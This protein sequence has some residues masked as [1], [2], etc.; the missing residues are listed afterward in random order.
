MGR[1]RSRCVAL[2]E[3]C[4]R[5]VRRSLKVLDLPGKLCLGADGGH[6]GLLREMLAVMGTSREAGMQVSA[7][8]FVRRVGQQPL[9]QVL[10]S[11]EAQRQP[12]PV[13]VRQLFQSQIP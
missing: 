5:P 9:S 11:L 3:G 1:Y 13:Q 4:I 2:G 10:G 8:Q 7:Q 12:L 6:Q